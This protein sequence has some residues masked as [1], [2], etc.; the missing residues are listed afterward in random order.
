MVQDS[1]SVTE[2][3]C[4]WRTF[5]T[6]GITSRLCN[7]HHKPWLVLYDIFCALVI[8]YAHYRLNETRYRIWSVCVSHSQG[9]ACCQAAPFVLCAF[10]PQQSFQAGSLQT[11]LTKYNVRK[12]FCCWK[13][14]LCCARK[15]TKSSHSGARD[16]A[17]WQARIE[18]NAFCH[19]EDRVTVPLVRTAGL[20]SAS[21]QAPITC[22]IKMVFFVLGGQLGCSNLLF[23]WA[24]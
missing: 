15:Q 16:C 21:V 3:C 10:H 5:K 17:V 14:P 2:A 13:Q 1:K 4:K 23:A 6:V 9:K 19:P 22:H 12:Q 18:M 7:L 20:G 11:K 24:F 8:C